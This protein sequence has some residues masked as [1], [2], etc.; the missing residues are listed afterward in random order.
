[1]DQEGGVGRRKALRRKINVIATSEATNF[2]R[3]PTR[4]EADPNADYF[5]VCSNETVHGHRLAEWPKHPNLVVDAS[6]RDHVAPAPDRAHARWSTR[7]AQKNLGPAGVVLAIVRK[8]LY[9]RSGKSVP[10]LWS[11]KEQ[12]EAKS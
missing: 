4:L 12:A 8:D 10:K 7:G 11:F 5:H 9:E 1:M 2:D 3:P 6:S